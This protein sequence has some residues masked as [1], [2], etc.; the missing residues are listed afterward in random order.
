MIIK[1]EKKRKNNSAHGLFFINKKTT[2]LFI[3]INAFKTMQRPMSDHLL[4]V[5]LNELTLKVRVYITFIV[6]SLPHLVSL[7]NKVIIDIYNF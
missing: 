4:R 5:P 3:S 6:K 7:R 2:Y 1:K